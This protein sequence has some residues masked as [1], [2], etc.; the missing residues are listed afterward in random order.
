MLCCIFKNDSMYIISHFQ[1]SNFSESLVIIYSLP[2]IHS[3]F[4]NHFHSSIGDY[5]ILVAIWYQQFQVILNSETRCLFYF[6][7]N[8]SSRE[9]SAVVKTW[10]R[11]SLSC[12]PG[13]SL[14]NKYLRFLK[15]RKAMMPLSVTFPQVII[16]SSNR[17][18]R[19]FSS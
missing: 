10:T 7:F 19:K 17:L 12:I 14:K 4:M 11:Y 5:I 8:F 3:P 2:D 18:F 6:R 9:G 1:L 16:S 15:C 13:R